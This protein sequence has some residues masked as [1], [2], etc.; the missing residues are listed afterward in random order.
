LKNFPEIMASMG[1]SVS[2]VVFGIA[3]DQDYLP[4]N[5]PT[6]KYN[7]TKLAKD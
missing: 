1:K 6:A 4:V 7:T 2:S 5:D 3:V